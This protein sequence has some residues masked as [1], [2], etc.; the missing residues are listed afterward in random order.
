MVVSMLFM[1]WKTPEPSTV[2]LWRNYCE[3]I[4]SEL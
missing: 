1:I 2:L 3:Y 4:F